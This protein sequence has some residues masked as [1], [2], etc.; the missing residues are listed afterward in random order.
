MNRLLLIFYSLCI[1]TNI[2]CKQ[3]ESQGKMSSQSKAS[4]TPLSFKTPEDKAQA[5]ANAASKILAACEE[6]HVSDTTKQVC[7]AVDTFT[8]LK[9]VEGLLK[10]SEFKSA[11]DDAQDIVSSST[12]TN[13]ATSTSVALGLDD[14]TAFLIAGVALISVGAIATIA[15]LAGWREF[16]NN[17]RAEKYIKEHLRVKTYPDIDILV[18]YMGDDWKAHITNGTLAEKLRKASLPEKFRIV[19][20]M[21]N[22][23]NSSSLERDRREAICNALGEYND[24]LRTE[25]DKIAQFRDRSLMNMPFQ[26]PMFNYIEEY[27]ARHKNIQTNIQN[28]RDSKPL[29]AHKSTRTVELPTTKTN[30]QKFSTLGK[31]KVTKLTAA[32]GIIGILGGVVLTVVGTTF[33]LTEGND[34]NGNN[35]NN[36]SAALLE[37]VNSMSQIAQTFQDKK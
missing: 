23:V 15:G 34:N 16:S 9:V 24:Q 37:F 35:P 3:R 19:N 8:D 2:Q 28:I 21:L 14:S 18:R 5:M 22:M 36:D 17:H 26:D 31:G 27:S 10:D 33:G 11:L 20:Y 6:G 7:K 4:T 32:A 30:F 25:L 29:V 12:S 13:T 1:L